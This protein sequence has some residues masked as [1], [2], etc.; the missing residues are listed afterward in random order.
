MGKNSKLARNSKKWPKTR[1]STRRSPARNSKPETRI[2]FASS[3]LEARIEK[4]QTRTSLVHNH[5][6]LARFDPFGSNMCCM[7]ILHAPN[8]VCC[9]FC[10]S[11]VNF[12]MSVLQ[13]FLQTF[14][15]RN[16]RE[17]IDYANIMRGA[18]EAGPSWISGYGYFFKQLVNVKMFIAQ[19]GF[20]CV[21]F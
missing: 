5:F 17:L 1:N 16:G 3:K 21:C 2:F 14:T 4:S 18:V 6:N 11:K 19:L 8:R 15:F 10:M 7:S 9:T 13:I 12:K 20:C